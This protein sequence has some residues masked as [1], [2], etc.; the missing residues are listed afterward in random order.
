VLGWIYS[1]YFGLA[2][3]IPSGVPCTESIFYF[4]HSWDLSYHWLNASGMRGTATL[5]PCGPSSP[6]PA[7]PE[8]TAEGTAA[9]EATIAP[10]SYCFVDNYG[11]RHQ[12]TSAGYYLEGT[13]QTPSCGTIPLIGAV[14][15]NIF[16]WYI[17]VPSGS[18]CLEGMLYAGLVSTLSGVWHT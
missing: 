13:T 17:D 2:Y 18:P 6:A 7:E 4:G 12:F 15:G 5:L 10:A 1:S 16:S 14:E 9:P 8:Q 11:Y 3:D